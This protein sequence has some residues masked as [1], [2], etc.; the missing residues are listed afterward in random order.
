M[1]ENKKIVIV[2]GGSGI[3]FAVAQRA[4]SAGAQVVIAS[5]SPETLQAAARQLGQAVQ[6]ELVDATDDQSV[7]EFLGRVGSFDHLAAT[8]KPTLPAGGF[9]ENDLLAVQA[10]F[11]AKFW[12]QY[13]L[14]KMAVPY[15]RAQGPSSSRRGLRHVAATPAI[16]LSVRSMLLPKPFQRPLPSNWRRSG[17]TASAL[18][19][20]IPCLRLPDAS[21][22]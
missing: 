12:G 15:I 2:G 13:R 18:A 17:S 16:R 7:A 5:R 4:V 20:W 8:I 11:E 10:A 21:R 9:V 19:L 6:V 14:A 3:G 1:L 22:M